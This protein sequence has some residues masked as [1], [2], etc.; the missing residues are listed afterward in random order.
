MLIGAVVH[1]CIAGF[2]EEKRMVSEKAIPKIFETYSHLMEPVFDDNGMLIAAS[3]MFQDKR[4]STTWAV[5]CEATS[6]RP[7]RRVPHS[8]GHGGNLHSREEES[9]Q[10]RPGE[11]SDLPEFWGFAGYACFACQGLRR[12]SAA[13]LAHEE[14]G[15]SIVGPESAPPCPNACPFNSG[16]SVRVDDEEGASGDRSCAIIRVRVSQRGEIH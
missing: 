9:D 15:D 1:C 6:G 12:R 2:S 5:K 16:R 3:F 10:R 11:R 7:L 4:V 13:A 8:G 14:S